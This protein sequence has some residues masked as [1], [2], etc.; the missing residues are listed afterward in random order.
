MSFILQPF[1]VFTIVAVLLKRLVPPGLSR[2]VSVYDK[3]IS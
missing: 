1:A 3:T 2:A